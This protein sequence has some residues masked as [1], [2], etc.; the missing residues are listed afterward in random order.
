MEAIG[1]VGEATSA[2]VGYLAIVSRLLAKPL[3]ILVQ[4]TSAAGKSTLTG[5]IRDPRTR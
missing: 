3:A 4:S 2:L 1:V 5:P